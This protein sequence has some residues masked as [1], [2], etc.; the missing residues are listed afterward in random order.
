MKKYLIGSDFTLIT[1]QCIAKPY[2]W[3]KIE[4]ESKEEAYVFAAKL[5]PDDIKTIW[6]IEWTPWREDFEAHSVGATFR[7]LE[8]WGDGI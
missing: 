1:W 5:W 4:A 2:E 7:S 6:V 8:F 3:T